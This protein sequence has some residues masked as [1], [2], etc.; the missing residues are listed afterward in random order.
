[1]VLQIYLL[2]HWVESFNNNLTRT[3][4][5]G[6]LNHYTDYRDQLIVGSQGR[7]IFQTMVLTPN[8]LKAAFEPFLES[9]SGMHESF[10]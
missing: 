7:S 3:V 10:F 8:I 4:L 6:V 5:G 1:M 2:S 9:W